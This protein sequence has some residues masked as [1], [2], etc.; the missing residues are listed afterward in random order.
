M[1][2]AVAPGLRQVEFVVISG[3]RSHVRARSKGLRRSLP[4]DRLWSM[5]P[6]IDIGAL[7]GGADPDA[8]NGVIG[9][10]DAACRTRGFFIVTNHGVPLDLI[11]RLDARAR[12]FFA[13]PQADKEAVAMTRGGRAW[14]GWFPLDGELTAGRPDHKEGYYFGEE[15]AA[16]DPRPMHGANLFPIEPADLGALVLAYIDEMTSL[17]HILVGAIDAALGCD[18]ALSAITQTPFV[19]LRLFGYPSGSD[20]WGVGEH[21]DYGMLTMLHQDDSGGLQ[22]RDG[23]AW[24]D[25]TPMPGTFVCNIGDMLDK[26][27]GGLYRSTPHRVRNASDRYR[28]SIPFFFDPGWDETVEPVIAPVGSGGVQRWDGADPHLFDGI[29]G[30]YIWSKVSK[31]FPELAD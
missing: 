18:G 1:V 4:P 5:L 24:I 9:Q 10:I 12:E 27:T 16:G 7:L 19:L 6:V 8:A 3:M 14:R 30:D 22:V 29:Y 2:S 17:G 11:A 21:T 25:V 26:A 15:R 31:V 13:L 20:G 23:D 28:V